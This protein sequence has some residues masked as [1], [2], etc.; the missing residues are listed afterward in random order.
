MSKCCNKSK[1][2]HPDHTEELTRLNRIGGQVSGVK[3]MIE[4]NRYCPD[5]LTQLKA[6]R[7]AI[8]TVEA[9]ILERHL[10]GCITKAIQDGSKKEQQKKIDEIKEIFKRYED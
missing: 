10:A 9:N 3:K 4:E 8:K 6:L 7:S 5:I 1:L 2:N